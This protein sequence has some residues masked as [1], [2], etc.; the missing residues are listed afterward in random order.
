LSNSLGYVGS[1]LAAV[2]DRGNATAAVFAGR[3]TG[4][5]TVLDL[6][7]RIAGGLRALGVEPGDRVAVLSANGDDYQALYLAIPWSGA[8][9][10]PLNTRWSP[11]ETGFAL[12]DCK[13]K[14]AFV[15]G[16]IDAMTATL[17]DARAA[18][19]IPVALGETA[20]PGWLRLYDLLSY[21][22]AEDAARAG[23]DLFGI[24]YTGGTTGRSK[25]V[26][27]SHANVLGNWMAMRDYGFCRD[28]G[29]GLVVAP[30]F[31]LAGAA[32]LTMTMVA[33]GAAVILPAFDPAGALDAIA[34]ERVTDAVLVPTMIQMLL[35][36]P[37]FDPAKLSALE[38]L[39]Y[40]ASPMPEATLDRIM[41]AAP[42]VDFFQAYGMTEL[43]AA[44]TISTP[45]LFR[46]PHREAGR[47]RGAGR[48]IVNTEVMIA[49]ENGQPRPRG[50]VGEILVRGPGVML[51]YWRQPELTAAAVRDGWMHTG[52]VGRLDDHDI[53]Y[54]IDRLKDMIVSGGENIYSAE[55]ENAIASHPDVA[56]CAVI[57]VPD[58]R[59]VERVHAVVVPHAG[60]SPTAESIIE[61]CRVLIADYK[62]PR[63]VEFRREPLP[64][65]AAGK[66]LKAELR[67]P[68]WEGQ[69]RNI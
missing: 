21:P 42:H 3:R 20:P 1:V 59:W 61:H 37:G 26:M 46:G 51:G 7:A 41:A 4:W 58:P 14:V 36:A 55:V 56:Q 16:D 30:L 10:A 50:E 68:Y 25:G 27:L 13:P 28:A 29:R 44:A 65:S 2:S 8:V 19:M 35:D 43:S 15:R 63:S 34:N 6:A 48:A 45:D 12:D 22:P 40:A 64:M 23:A 5:A 69:S 47:H 54:I 38:S 57:G 66:I 67:K 60:A 17:F 32:M 39:L 62:C 52:D 24:F 9:I 31:H 33:G 18:E 49:D 53:L 11:V